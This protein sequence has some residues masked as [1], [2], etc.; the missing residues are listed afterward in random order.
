M[1]VPVLIMGPSGSGKTYS[2]HTMQNNSYGL[3]ECEKTMLSF[4][5]G[6]K[7]F[8][9]TRDF[10]ELKDA[11]AEYAGRYDRVVVDDFGYCITEIYM[12]GSWGE[13]KYRD[14][15]DVFKEI[16][17]RVWDFIHFVEDLD[18]EGRKIVYLT[19]HTDVDASGNLVPATVGKMLNEKIN[20]LGMFGVVIVA[21]STADG[22]VFH[23]ENYGPAKS[24][25]AFGGDDVIPNDLDMVD[26][27]LRRVIWGDEPKDGEERHD[28]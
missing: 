13:Q 11:V 16:G 5:S 6:G 14:Q 9:R 3:V 17:G 4:A 8:C 26:A 15:Y 25:G 1:A 12:R 21:E 18:P 23:V 28:A 10:G 22:H 2:L 7:R 27:A 19:M 20:L 24:S